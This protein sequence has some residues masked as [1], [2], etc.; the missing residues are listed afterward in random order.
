MYILGKK[1]RLFLPKNE[2]L[3]QDDDFPLAILVMLRVPAVFFSRSV[4]R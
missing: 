1:I 4:F 2:V 3:V